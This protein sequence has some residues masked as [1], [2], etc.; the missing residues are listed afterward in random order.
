MFQMDTYD[1]WKAI[2]Q[3][4]LL[5]SATLILLMNKCDIL[6][7]KLKSGPS[8]VTE[9][10]YLLTDEAGI[11]FSRNVP[12]YTGPNEFNEVIQC[13]SRDEQCSQLQFPDF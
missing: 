9:H 7:A 1:L 2:C 3:N 8:A 12:L 5:S 13:E 6:K 11:Q 4:K 10:D